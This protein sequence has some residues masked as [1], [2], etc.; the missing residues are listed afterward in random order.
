MSTDR[1]SIHKAVLLHEVVQNFVLQVESQKSIKSVKS[2]DDELEKQSM[3]AGTSFEG[4]PESLARGWSGFSADDSAESPRG[5]TRTPRKIVP[6]GMRSDKDF[7]Y[8][9]G[10][11][12]G[13]GHALAMA[14]AL[15]GKLTIIGLDRDPQAIERAKETLK[16]RAE[17]VI[18][19]TED[20]RNLDKVLIKYKIAKADCILLD[21]GISSDELENSGRGFSFQ[22]DEPLLMTFG[23]PATHPFTASTIVNSW[24]EEDIANVIYA[25]GEERYARRI[26]KAIV[27][28]RRKK[29]IETSGELAEIIKASV[30]SI[31]RYGR[32]HPATRTFQ[33]LRIAVNDELAAL[34][35]GLT[36]AWNAL[37]KGGRLAV[38]SFHSLEDRI[39]KE[40]F[41][42]KV[43]SRKYSVESQEKQ[44]SGFEPG[45]GI[46][47]TKKP[48]T[49][50]PQ[51][52]SENPRSRS[53]K[54][55]IIEKF[56]VPSA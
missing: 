56:P 55:R 39:V 50:S 37:D 20:F 29:R 3:E 11:I 18:L 38:I 12:G 35:E 16:G 52:I 1:K 2:E 6:A 27:D 32:I 41:K 9:D 19:E 28:Y 17:K 21:L 42:E 40:F 45:N 46:I 47:I 51:E 4:A 23:D 31:Y 48:I 24:K 5:N 34:K 25:Y 53:A 36:K 33:A 43:E 7:I 13:A 10:T 8:V 44:D 54:L 14:K 26:A 22:K 30:P 15:E 49:A